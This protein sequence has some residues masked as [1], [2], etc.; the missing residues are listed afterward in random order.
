MLYCV[1]S[2]RTRAL[3]HVSYRRLIFQW[4]LDSCSWF[5]FEAADAC[6]SSNVAQRC[7]LKMLEEICGV[8]PVVDTWAS[9]VQHNSCSQTKTLL[10]DTRVV[11][12]LSM[13]VVFLPRT[14]S[15]QITAPWTV[16]LWGHVFTAAAPPLWKFT[17][18]KIFVLLPLCKLNTVQLNCVAAIVK[19]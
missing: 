13:L 17:V 12:C 4:R 14:F 2:I 11:S 1:F 10:C 16:C 3:N 9:Q 8:S 19:S 7:F 15:V 6:W 5:G 18:F